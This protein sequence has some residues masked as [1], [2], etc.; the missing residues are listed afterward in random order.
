MN[1]AKQVEAETAIPAGTAQRII[2]KHRK[3]IADRKTPKAE[4]LKTLHAQL[5]KLKAEVQ[6][7][8][9]RLEAK[10]KE[11]ADLQKLIRKRQK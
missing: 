11:I 1:L 8:T 10:K 9:L 6:T 4:S 2:A 7:I 5:D 3:A